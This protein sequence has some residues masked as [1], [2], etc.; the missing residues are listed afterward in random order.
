MRHLLTATARAGPGPAAMMNVMALSPRARPVVGRDADLHRLR[1]AVGLGPGAAQGGLVL[2]SGDAGIGKSRLVAELAHEAGTGGWLVVAGH[3]VG[4]S[5]SEMPYL[6]FTELLGELAAAASDVLDAVQQRI[7]DLGVLVPALARGVPLAP[8]DAARLA[9]A[10]HACLTEVASRQPLL[11]V[12][13]DVHWA[14]HSS[15]DLLSL[16]LARGFAEPVGLVVT[17]RS[18]DLHRRHPLHATLPSWT[19]L[20]HVTRLE[21][22]RLPDAAMRTLVAGLD[23][24]PTDDSTLIDLVERAEGNAFFAEELV[25]SG[26]P[27]E[28]RGEDL[29]R[30]LRRRVEQLSGPAE[31]AVRA[32][33]VGGRTVSHELLTAV[34]GL[35]DDEF[36]IAVG[37]AV[38]HHVLVPTAAGE[39]SF[40]H[41]L[42]AEAVA[43]D[44]LPGARKR[45]HTAYLQALRDDPTLGGPATR[46]HH[47]I[48]VGDTETAIEASIAAGRGAMELAGPRDAL[49]HYERALDLLDDPGRRAEVSVLAAGAASTAGDQ[50][51]AVDLLRDALETTPATTLPGERALLLAE[52]AL[53][54][55]SLDLEG[56]PGALTQ[57]AMTLVSHA[58]PEHQV[59][60][61]FAR[62]QTY[63]DAGDYDRAEGLGEEL[64]TQVE[65]LGLGTVAAEV[66]LLLSYVVESRIHPDQV[67]ER[68]RRQLAELPPDHPLYPRSTLRL[69]NTLASLGRLA[70][71]L[72]TFELGYAAAR[73]TGQIW[74]PFAMENRLFGAVAAH[75][76]GAWDR[77][78]ELLDP[79]ADGVVPQPGGALIESARL[80]LRASRGERVS[81]HEIEALAPWWSV[82]ALAAAYT[83]YAAIDLLGSAG[84]LRGM[85]EVTERAMGDIVRAW[86]R[87]NQGT[88]RVAALLAGRVADHVVEPDLD[89]GLRD[90]LL[91]AVELYATA[92]RSR[93]AAPATD[94]LPAPGPESR[95]WG[96]RLEAELLR[97]SSVV[98]EE[99]D[100]SAMVTA[101]E[102]AVG[103]FEAY[104]QPPEVARSQLHLAQALHAAGRAADARAVAGRAHD[105]A[106]RL[107][108]SGLLERLS[109]HLVDWGVA[110][111]VGVRPAAAVDP[112][113]LELTP[114]EREVLALVAQGRTNGQIG[115]ALFIST[116]TVSVHVSNVLAKLGAA[117]RAEAAAI[118]RRAGLV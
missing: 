40:R 46:A 42:L 107:G 76:L 7:P 36:E 45:L 57:E 35:D 91:E 1:G 51:R 82:D 14:D 102:R 104:G 97:L 67:V 22:T 23:G 83:L 92:A 77:A 12:V 90:R 113:P 3:C 58:R 80:L 94:R 50:L 61:R 65:A 10:V 99:V 56:D 16:I 13:E 21:L 88:I 48:A 81:R 31:Q 18:D 53:R 49:R 95:A 11:V 71:S 15:R 103:A 24:A 70:E 8:P 118:A 93:L 84:D 112:G 64:L 100:P 108:M 66:R 4:L 89:S 44:L 86:S 9:E 110:P 17:Y 74:A 85:L 20:P 52:L 30:L 60:V 33:A 111:G 29:G 79:H 5:G 117:N 59:T 68:M 114:R 101:W 37:E 69:A 47:A 63:L 25:A 78:D 75:Q 87:D 109:P 6:P 27:R 96:A 62:L 2:V 26:A 116:K 43:A 28:L 38:E 106:E 39:Y 54:L 41:A 72:E 98:G 19:R 34:T 115:V 73:R 105:T 32:A 55:R